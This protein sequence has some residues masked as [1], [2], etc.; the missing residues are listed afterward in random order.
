MEAGTD[1][2]YTPPESDLARPTERGE[3]FGSLEKGLRGDFRFS[4]QE[5]LSEAWEL[6][7]GSK[8]AIVGG[9]A[10]YFA[11]SMVT[12]VL[13]AAATG[14]DPEASVGAGR[15]I[16][17]VAIE[18]LG[19]V[20]IYPLLAGIMLYSVKR[21]AGDPAASFSDNFACYDRTFSIIA[22]LVVQGVVVL[23]GL[24]L[25]VIPGLYLSVAY[26]LA[27]PLLVE[28]NMG[29]WEAMETS[30]KAV[31]HCWFR[32]WG[33]WIVMSLLALVGATVTLG[34]GLIWLAPMAM[35]AFGVAYRDIFGY[36]GAR[37]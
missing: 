23:L 29:V 30:R 13:S 10:I 15:Q 21:A 3:N 28:K 9:F 31:T 1:S 2:I 37:A 14:L 20:L 27:F 5:I 4:I 22:L 24:L 8:A 12:S 26:G 17:G 19:F 33:L 18:T 16:L 34:I 35:L 7:S 36:E 32:F 6:T 11:I 25:F